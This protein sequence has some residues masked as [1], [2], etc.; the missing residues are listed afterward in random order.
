MLNVIVLG[1]FTAAVV[2]LKLFA[3]EGGCRMMM[4]AV[5]VA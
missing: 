2:G 3:I 1:L 4:L 5:T